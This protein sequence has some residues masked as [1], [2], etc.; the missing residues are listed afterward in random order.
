MPD[1]T[2]RDAAIKY[3][4]GGWT[5]MPLK[6]DGDGLPKKPIIDKWTRLTCDQVLA[7]PWHGACGLGLVLGAPSKGLC[8][9]DVD[10]TVMAADCFLL[11]TY[12]RM[13]RT[14][15][16]R[17]HLYFFEDTPSKST[18]VELV[19]KGEKLKV[20]FKT[21]GT[22]VAA[23]PTPRYEIAVNTKVARVPSI[24]HAFDD[25]CQLL[26]IDA[27][28]AVGGNAGFP[29]PW[30]ERVEPDNRNKSAFIEASYL[31]DARMPEGLAMR[32]MQIRWSEDYEPGDQTWDEIARTVESAYHR[33]SPQHSTWGS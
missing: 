8:V 19:Y 32:Y 11:P 30:A 22:Q 29:R 13:I 15:R 14:I 33:Q 10:S 5:A 7:L 9:L 24:R 3:A 26:G 2:L 1:T 25:L 16:G 17:G 20:E 21:N 28:T 31:R 27:A 18:Y 12:T 6:L 4:A 23:P